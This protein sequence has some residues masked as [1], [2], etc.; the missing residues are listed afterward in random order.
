MRSWAFAL[1]DIPTKRLGPAIAAAIR[2]NKTSFQ[3]TTGQVNKAYD[4][5]LPELERLAREQAAQNQP[6]RLAG[7]EPK[8]VSPADFRAK[9]NLPPD[10]KL[11]DPY[12]E[13][14]DLRR[15]QEEK[16][17]SEGAL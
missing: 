12:P 8:Y 16:L 9:H 6:R 2:A 15:A 5:M 17:S 1:E 10:W 14:S 13:G 4:D 3:L 11:G 7:P